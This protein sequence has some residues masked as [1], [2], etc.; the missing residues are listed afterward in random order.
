MISR[1]YARESLINGR[2]GREG[3]GGGMEVTNCFAGRQDK[4][5]DLRQQGCSVRK[6]KII[7]GEEKEKFSGGNLRGKKGRNKTEEY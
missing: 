6:Q 7:R 2:Q 5:L 1:H 3:K 4:S